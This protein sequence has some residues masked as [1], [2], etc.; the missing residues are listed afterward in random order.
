M[1]QIVPYSVHVIQIRLLTVVSIIMRI[2]RIGINTPMHTALEIG[3]LLTVSM[4][5][6]ATKGSHGVKG[7]FTYKAHD[8]YIWRLSELMMDGSLPLTGTKG[9]CKVSCSIQPSRDLTVTLQFK[10]RQCLYSVCWPSPVFIT[11]FFYVALFMPYYGLF[12]RDLHILD[13]WLRSPLC[14]L[15]FVDITTVCTTFM[16]HDTLWHHNGSWHCYECP[17]VAQQCVMTLLGTSIVMLQW[18]MTLLCT[19]NMASQWIMTLLWTFFA[20]YYYAKLWYCCFT[21]EIFNIEH[22]N[23]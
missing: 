14:S 2:M 4:P 7:S 3:F 20:M 16:F 13:L 10:I 19:H 5:N 1:I 8:S 17:I 18:I 11:L 9:P 12:S 6:W 21:S 23:H 15:L 22:I